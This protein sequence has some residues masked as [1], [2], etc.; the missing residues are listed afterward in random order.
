MKRTFIVIATVLTMVFAACDNTPKFHV[1]GTITDAADS[2][3]YLS[4]ITTDGVKTIDSTEL[5]EDGIFEFESVAPQAPEFYALHLNR[6]YIEF[7]IDSTETVTFTANRETMSTNYTVEGSENSLRIK[8]ISTMRDVLEDSILAVEKNEAMYPGD[9]TDSV[10]NMVNRYKAIL[11]K[12]YMQPAPATAAAYYALLSSFSDIS[13]SYKLFSPYK[14]REDARCYAMVATA[15]ANL[16]PTST[17][18]IRLWDE[19]EKAMKHTAPRRD[20]VIELDTNKVSETGIIDITLP[21]AKSKMHSIK[22]L[23]GKV[24]LLDFTLYSANESVGRTRNMHALY[25]KYNAQG[26]EIYQ[27]SLDADTHFWKYSV[28]KLPWIC[29]HETDGRATQSYG[30]RTLPTFFLINRNNEVVVRSDFMEG[31]LES[32]ILK[33]L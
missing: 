33:L 26:F 6:H 9:I 2:M 21:D 24:V 5:S 3:L 29:T 23:K 22:E 18:A 32:N 13:G 31:T 20:K 28:E 17:R 10:T 27:V 7:S 30:V 14:N 8:E 25:D 4:A 12:K 11:I 15:W 1:R 16:Y 19:A